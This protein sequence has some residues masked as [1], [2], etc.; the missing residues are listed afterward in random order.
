MAY[1]AIPILIPDSPIQQARLEMMEAAGRLATGENPQELLDED[2]EVRNAEH[3]FA[4]VQ[5]AIPEPYRRLVLAIAARIPDEALT[6]SGREGYPHCTV[7]WGVADADLAAIRAACAAFPGPARLFLGRTSAWSTPDG[8]CV[9]ID[10]RS[11]D[12]ADLRRAIEAAAPDAAATFPF[13]PHITLAYVAPGRG[14]EFAGWADLAGAEIAVDALEMSG[15]ADAIT[16]LPLGGRVAFIGAG[17]PG[18]GNHG[19]AGRPGERGGSAPKSAGTAYGRAWAAQD[20]EWRAHVAK[21]MRAAKGAD[22]ALVAAIM[23][24]APGSGVI[25]ETGD[26]TNRIIAERGELFPQTGVTFTLNKANFCHQNT[27]KLYGSRKFP[28]KAFGIATGYYT[29][30]KQGAWRSHSWL[31]DRKSGAVVETT[32]NRGMTYFGVKLNND[33]AA[34]FKQ[35]G[36]FPV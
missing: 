4:S 13:E 26:P 11:E 14:G 28:T 16:A 25:L 15:Q 12:L 3:A 1:E 27:A 19:H 20:P 30:K 21:R 18:S 7:R 36:G 32:G 24:V 9:K 10:V 23:A 8:D 29:D 35:T 2:L 22:R 5:V 33:E 17:G 31:F 34:R 6:E